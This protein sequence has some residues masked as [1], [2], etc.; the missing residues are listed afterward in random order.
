MTV[1]NMFHRGRRRRAGPRRAGRD[2]LRVPEGP[3]ERPAGRR[4]GHGPVAY[5]KSLLTDEGRG[6]RPRMVT[7]DATTLTPPMSPGA[8]TRARGLP[9]QRVRPG[10]RVTPRTRTAPRRALTYMGLTAG[11]PLPGDRRGHGVRRLVPPTA[12]SRTCGAAAD[13]IKGRERSPTASACWSS[14]GRCRS[15]SRRR[16]R[17]AWARSFAAARRRVALRPAARCAWA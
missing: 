11:T 10:R 2:H 15:G 3:P 5:W 14:P 9:L 8:P 17:G 13:V 7:I 6:L 4:L 12:G 1:C 16:G